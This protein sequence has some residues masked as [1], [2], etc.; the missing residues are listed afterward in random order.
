MTPPKRE[1]GDSYGCSSLMP[2]ETIQNVTQGGK[3]KREP[4]GTL[5]SSIESLEIGEIKVAIIHEAKNQTEESSKG[6]P[7]TIFEF[8]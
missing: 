1:K 5:E 7:W 8:C 4:G 6:L 2:G 3:T